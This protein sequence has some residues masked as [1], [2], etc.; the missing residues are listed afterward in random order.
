MADQPG[1]N[2]GGSPASGGS[3]PGFPNNTQIIAFDGWKGLNTRPARPALEAEECY[4]LQNFM[5]VG[6]SNTRTLYGVGTPLFTSFSVSGSDPTGIAYFGFGNIGA[7]VYCVFFPNDGSIRVMNVLTLVT[8]TIAPHY[9]ITSPAAGN[10]GL[11]QYGNQYIIIS[12]NQTNGY[13]LWDGTLLYSPGTLGPDVNITF[14]GV[15]YTS[16]STLTLTPCGDAAHSGG[17]GS[18]ATFGATLTSG[19]ISSITVSSAGSGYTYAD[20]MYLA[21]SGGGCAG[22]TPIIKTTVSGGIITATSIVNGGKGFTSSATAQVLGG[23]GGGAS[24]TVTVTS[25]SVSALAIAKGGEG[26]SS[27]PAVYITDPNNP[28]AEA[29]LEVMPFGVQGT[30]METF[31]GIVWIAK[32]NTV[33]FTAPGYAANF[34]PAYGGGAY[35]ST[36]SF[37]RNQFVGLRQSNGF[38]YT[39]ADSSVNNISNVATSLASS[40]SPPITTFSNNNID[41]QIG[42]PWPL[43][44]QVFSR[45][46]VYANISGVYVSY[47]GAVVKVSSALDGI[48]ASLPAFGSFVPSSAVANIFGINVYIILLPVYDPATGSQINTMFCWDGQHWFSATQEVPLSLI[49]TLEIN[50]ELSVWG[51][52]PPGAIYPLFQTPS[53]SLKKQITSKLWEDPGYFITKVARRLY[54]LLSYNSI[55]SPAVTITVDNGVA[56]AQ[57]VTVT[58]ISPAAW[59]GFGGVTATW[60]GAGGVAATWNLTAVAVLGPLAFA[61]AGALTGV[62]LT[63][64]AADMTLLSLTMIGQSFST[65]V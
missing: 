9:T 60:T 4:I 12:A 23:G 32:G 51:Y 3:N 16:L 49:S 55:L 20:A 47:G 37:L 39:F 36:D 33:L 63:T 21:F 38:L 18:S 8:A 17:S 31:Q 48:F 42:T 58:P 46:I 22:A 7:T 44:I 45:N 27:S 13:W 30:A 1:Q 65:N 29:T 25:G 10:I 5:P 50:S 11:T 26:Y 6:K 52:S 41:P 2:G 14:A 57:S 34:S 19:T 15:D 61:Q 43:T 62:S 40:N 59:T 24:I 28:V 56:G 53:I 35:K 54:G 64:N